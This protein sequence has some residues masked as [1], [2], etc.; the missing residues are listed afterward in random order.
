MEIIQYKPRK[1]LNIHKHADGGWFWDKYTANPYIGCQHSCEFCYEIGTKYSP[2]KTPEEFASTIKVKENAPA[3]LRKELAKVPKDI[4]VTG[5]YQPIEAKYQLSRQ[6]LEICLEYEFPVLIIERSPLVLKDLDLISEINKRSWA[7]VIFSVSYG[8]SEGYRDVFEPRSPRVETRFEAMREISSAGVHTGVAFMPILPFISD[9]DENIES[10]VNQTKENGGEF[11]LAGGLSLQYQQKER[12]MSLIETH[13][14]HLMERYDKYFS[15][16]TELSRKYTA[17]VGRKVRKCCEKYGILDRMLRYI[18]PGELAI[19]KKVSEKLFDTLYKYD[20]SCE[21]TYKI[22]AYRKTAWVIDE[23]TESVEKIYQEGGVQGIAN[24]AGISRHMA[25]KIA[26]I[27]DT[28]TS[29][30]KFN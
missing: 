13:Y 11:V 22:W 12:Y 3:L 18:V 14:P 5:D 29:E 6:L 26:L 16:T 25:G 10:V 19:N 7:C 21:S 9:S 24:I 28:L 8:T 1:I 30:K 17:V 20:L 27:L 23:L 4:I 2:Y 15:A